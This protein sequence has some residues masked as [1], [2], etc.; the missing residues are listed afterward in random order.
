MPLGLWALIDLERRPQ[1]PSLRL[2]LCFVLQTLCSVYYGVFFSMFLSVAAAI[3]LVIHRRDVLSGRLA[4]TIKATGLAAVAA[5]ILLL[6]YVAKYSAARQSIERRP[7]EEITRF[8]AVP[9]DYLRVARD[10]KVLTSE[11]MTGEEERSLFPGL[12]AIVLVGLAASMATRAAIPYLILLAVTVELSFGMN[13]FVYPRLLEW[14]PPLTGLRAPARFGSLV[15]L[16]VAVLGSLGAARLQASRKVARYVLPALAGAMLFEYWA[17]PIRIRERPTS[18]PPAYVWLAKQPRGVVLELPMPPPKELWAFETE[19]QLMSIYHWQRLVNGYSG[20]AP[21]SYLQI[22]ETLQTFP[23]D[24]S[25]G[26]LRELGV[27]WVLIHDGLMTSQKFADLMLRVTDSGA[28]RVVT[29]FADGM[30]K[31]VVLELTPTTL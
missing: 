18:A 23:S 9:S 20:S 17:A 28:F 27:R 31:A 25:I 5:A 12:V 3:M 29:T 4:T 1:R 24:V 22:C 26:R 21:A 6:P 2:A 15:L 8:S 19:Y 14:I 30:G 16:S 13:G 7:V 10:N 11:P